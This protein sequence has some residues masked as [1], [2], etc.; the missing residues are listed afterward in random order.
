MLKVVIIGYGEMFTNMIAATLDSKNK[1]V[2]VLRQETIKY[3]PF[4]RWIKDRINPSFE[5]NY[6]KSYKLPEI[7]S[8]KSVNSEKFKKQLLKLNPDII[9]VASWGEK[10][11][12]EIY[13]LPKIA[14]I[15]VHPSLLPK[16]RGPN[17]YFW[18]IKNQEKKSGVTFHLVDSNYDTGAILAQEE[19][20][21]T[22]NE[23][24][25]SLKKKTVLKARGVGRELLK[26]LNDDIIIPLQQREDCATYFSTP[27]DLELDFK[28]SAEE[29][30]AKIR[31]IYDWGETYFYHGSTILTPNVKNIEIIEN[32]TNYSS[33]GTIVNVNYKTKMISV[34]C[35]DGKILKMENINLYRKYDRIFTSNYIKQEIHIGDL[36]L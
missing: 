14:T 34:L 30:L 20:E 1:I 6:I 23:T 12:K 27:C 31:A 28:K 29:N 7:L 2:G 26:A 19:I 21:I 36:I 17:P 33:A 10:L 9:L 4:L 18:V 16:Y 8:V 22:E 13:T 3:N 15:N 11:K 24:G 25:K 35:E 32:N 5:Y